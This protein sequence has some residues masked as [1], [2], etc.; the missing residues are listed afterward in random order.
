MLRNFLKIAL[1]NLLKNKISSLINLIGLSVG[2]ASCIIIFLYIMQ[3]LSYDDFH[4]NKNNIYRVGIIK[5]SPTAYSKKSQTPMPA[6]P[7]LDGSFPEVNK[8]CRVFFSDNDNFE[9]GEKNIVENNLI[10][11]DSTFF[12]VFSFELL[13]GTKKNI[14][15]APYSIVMTEN[16]AKKYFGDENPIGKQLYINNRKYFNVTG[17]V[18]APP[19]N[20]HI[21][22]DFIA[23]YNSLTMDFFGQDASNAWGYYFGNY[24]YVLLN[25]NA[26]VKGLANKVKKFTDANVPTYASGATLE[27]IF[28][29]LVETHT[30]VSFEGTPEPTVSLTSLT[31]LSTIGMFLLLIACINFVNLTTARSLSRFKE[32]GVRKTIGAGRFALLRQFV[33]ESV[34]FTLIALIIAALLSE[35]LLTYLPGLINIKITQNIFSNFINI[36]SILS[37]A[38]L[39]GVLSGIYPALLLARMNTTAIIK[40]SSSSITNKTGNIF[41]KKALVILQFAIAVIFIAATLIVNDQLNYVQTASLGFEKDHIIQLRLSDSIVNFNEEEDKTQAFKSSL[42]SIPGIKDVC[43]G[44]GAPLGS[45]YGT[46]IYPNGQSE[47]G[48]FHIVVTAIDENYIDFFGMNLLAGENY[49]TNR[50]EGQRDDL[51]I[52]ETMMH[53]LGYS[54]PQKVLYKRYDLGMNNITGD[55]MGVVSDFHNESFRD[56]ITPIAFINHKSLRR[57]AS[58]K[59]NSNNIPNTIAEIKNVWEQFSPSYPMDLSFLDE[60]INRLYEKEQQQANLII[61]F[62]IIAIVISCM[63]LFGLSAFT[64]QQRTKEIGIRKV[65]GATVSNIIMLLSKEFMIL[66]ITANII[67]LPIAYYFMEQWLNNFAY[68]VDLSAWLFVISAV[69]AV[70]IAFIT[71]SYQAAKAALADPVKSLRYE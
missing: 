10:F 12:E 59:I 1:R 3:E 70:S 58:L 43:F 17:I 28:Q 53:K 11:A 66:T 52:N 62:S 51:I 69:I 8:V 9:Y 22:F 16:S 60:S 38:V 27:M 31:I 26:S 46:N 6:G 19:E 54:D 42:L 49:S 47:P 32:I 36:L 71:V 57:Q 18:K 56:D 34:L 61:L 4:T 48:A 14:L 35:I 45:R 50:Y 29:P 2:L 13:Y 39:V 25:E 41:L 63:G 44:T 5:E 37:I 15:S 21:K 68:R 24:T 64:A 65:I 7:A 23:S 20:T 40:G 67:A 30:D 33:G 55:I